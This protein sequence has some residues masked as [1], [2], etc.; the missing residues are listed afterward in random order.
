[1]QFRNPDC[2]AELYVH[3]WKKRFIRQIDQLESRSQE[4]GLRDEYLIIHEA[5][6]CLRIALI[7]DTDA[8]L[9]MARDEVP[10]EQD[11]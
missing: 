2:D 7:K 1:M 6:N 4:L 10:H 5:A 11:D 9:T 3:Y 8:V